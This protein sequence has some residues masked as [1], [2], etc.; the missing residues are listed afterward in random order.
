MSSGDP[1]AVLGGH[2]T[3]NLQLTQ[4]PDAITDVVVVH[5]LDVSEPSP[6]VALKKEEV[7]DTVKRGLTFCSSPHG[8]ESLITQ[9]RHQPGDSA[10]SDHTIPPKSD[11]SLLHSNVLAITIQHWSQQVFMLQEAVISH[12]RNEVVIVSGI[13]TVTTL[14]F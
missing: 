4:T 1:Y 9:Q 5:G 3:R 2:I 7:A 14:S 6:C 8:E 12:V 11:H 13:S 10:L